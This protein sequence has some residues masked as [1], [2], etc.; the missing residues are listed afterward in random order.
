MKKTDKL[1]KINIICHYWSNSAILY[2]VY[3]RMLNVHMLLK[4]YFILQ[5]FIN[6]FP[7]TVFSLNEP[8]RILFG[9]ISILE[10]PYLMYMI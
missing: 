10:L 1:N 9:N 3:R 4:L 8:N 6:V 5:I 2:I 7:Y